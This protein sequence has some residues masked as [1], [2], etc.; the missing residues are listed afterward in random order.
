[1]AGG[2]SRGIPPSHPAHPPTHPAPC[3]THLVTVGL[4]GF[5]Q[6]GPGGWV[7]GWVDGW[8]PAS[9]GRGSAGGAGPLLPAC[10]PGGLRLLPR[11]TATLCCTL[12]RCR[13]H[14]AT[15]PGLAT[16]PYGGAEA[17]GTDF[18]STNLAAGVDFAEF[19][20]YPENWVGGGGGGREVGREKRE[21]EEGRLSSCRQWGGAGRVRKQLRHAL[22]RAP[23]W[24][25]SRPTL[26]SH[27]CAA[28][29]AG[30]G[31]RRLAD[32]CAHLDQ[33]A[34][35]GRAHSAAEACAGQGAGRRGGWLACTGSCG[36]GV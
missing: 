11:F 22:L 34:L 12:R 25:R 36:A 8:V 6:R 19:N 7:G 24:T 10:A 17:L 26:P 1:M 4:D 35:G 29:P 9:S 31:P 13:A 20:V 21:E 2:E 5:Y 23:Q 16:N 30:R 27:P 32:L 14:P 3:S 33:P 28:L 18:V 15:P